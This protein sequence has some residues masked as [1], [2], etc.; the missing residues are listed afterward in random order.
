M[1]PERLCQLRSHAIYRG[2]HCQQ[3]HLAAYMNELCDEIERLERVLKI[4]A[5]E[6]NWIKIPVFI[7]G[8]AQRFAARAIGED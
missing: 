3:S 2:L 8:D 6:V 7:P 5:N 1:T 4:F